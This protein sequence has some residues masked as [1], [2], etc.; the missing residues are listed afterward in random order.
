M[1]GSPARNSESH[2]GVAQ[3]GGRW[4]VAPIIDEGNYLPKTT[5]RHRTRLRGPARIEVRRKPGDLLCSWKNVRCA[6]RNSLS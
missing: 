5:T 6:S 1:P 4:A 3:E 2:V